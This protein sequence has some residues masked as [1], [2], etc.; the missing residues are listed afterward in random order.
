[1]PTKPKLIQ[2]SPNEVED[3]YYTALARADLEGL[4]ALWADDEDVVCVHPGSPR[5][6]GLNA[7]RQSWEQIFSKGS[8]NIQPAHTH[9]VMGLMTAVFNVVEQVRQDDA[10]HQN[11]HI[12]ATN[13]YVKTPRGWKMVAHHASIAPGLPQEE[14]SKVVLH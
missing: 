9:V 10:Q 14:T 3:A 4:M 7:I 5:L 11:I 6:L 8:I 12:L 1:M 13:V 2:D